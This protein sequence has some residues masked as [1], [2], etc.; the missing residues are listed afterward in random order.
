MDDDELQSDAQ[1]VNGESDDEFD[2][3]SEEDNNFDSL[4][5][6]EYKDYNPVESSWSL[7]LYLAFVDSHW[8]IKMVMVTLK[9]SLFLITS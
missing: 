9:R 5:I 1:F 8:N 3:N 7:V 6:G 2:M 4:N